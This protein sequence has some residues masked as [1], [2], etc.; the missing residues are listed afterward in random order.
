MFLMADPSLCSDLTSH[1]TEVAFRV[2]SSPQRNHGSGLGS[3]PEIPHSNDELN[4]RREKMSN[5]ERER[6]ELAGKF[7]N[8]RA[9]VSIRRTSI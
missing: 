8:N 1:G 7:R 9:L 4:D 5:C 3:N 2:S 6:R